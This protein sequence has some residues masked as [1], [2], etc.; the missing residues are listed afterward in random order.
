VTNADAIAIV[1]MLRHMQSEPLSFDTYSVA[2][3]AERAADA[4]D[5]LRTALTASEKDAARYRWLRK[6]GSNDFGA[7]YYRAFEKDG[8]GG[9]TLKFEADLDAA[10]DQEIS[11]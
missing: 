11:P 8:Y 7:D 6:G 4:I 3:A 5:A 9:S 2:G 1:A 10:I